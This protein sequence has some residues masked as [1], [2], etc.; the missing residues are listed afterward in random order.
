M[1]KRVRHIFALIILLSGA[2]QALAQMNMPDKVCVGTDRRYWVE[3]GLPGSIFTWTLDGVEIKSSTDSFV[4]VT[5]SKAKTYQ[6]QV[7]EH[8][9]TCDG[10]VQSGVVEVDDPVLPLFAKIDPICQ[11]SI[12]PL[13][14]LTSTNGIPGTWNPA[15]ISTATAGTSTY[16]FTPEAG[17]CATTTTLDI[18]ILKLTATPVA[19]NITCYGAGDGTFTVSG[20]SGGSGS[21]EYSIDGGISWIQESAL[22]L[23]IP[24]KGIYTVQMRD[25]VIPGCEISLG[26]VEI[27]EP[28]QLSA[29]PNYTNATCLGNDGTITVTGAKGGWGN[30]KY[31]I[32][33]TDWQSS[34]NF[35]GLLPGSYVVWI[36]DAEV[37]GCQISLGTIVIIKPEPLT[38]TLSKT[39]VTCFNGNDGTI[40]VSGPKNG[41]GKYEFSLDGNLWQSALQFTGLSAGPFT[42]QIRDSIAPGCVDTIG[43]VTLSEPDKLQASTSFT[44]VKCFG[45]HDGSISVYDAKGGSG[46]YQ[47]TVDGINWQSSQTFSGLAPIKYFVLMSDAKGQNCIEFISEITITEPLQMQASVVKNDISCNGAKDGK[48]LISNPAN[49]STPYQFTIDDGT[50]TPI[51]STNGSF[52]GLLK[53]DYNVKMS[54]AKGCEQALG[55]FTIVEPDPLTA[56]VASTNATCLGNDGTITITN[57]A[58]SVSGNYEYCINGTNWFA[59]GAFKNLASGTY[60]VKIRDANLSSCERIL[61][62]RIISEPTP[63]LATAQKTDVTCHG[64]NDG[65]I[66][67][68]THQ[69]GSGL[70]EYSVDGTNWNNLQ[71][72]SGLKPGSYTL[73]MHDT[74][75]P[76]CFITIGVFEIIEPDMLAATA[77]AFPVTCFGG[78]D[79]KITF[80][81]MSGGS[82][83]WEFSVDGT[84]W[85]TDKIEKLIAGVYTVQ[86]RDANHPTCAIS[87]NPIEITEPP[88]LTATVTPANVTCFGGIDGKISITHP[89]NGVGPYQFSLD[90]IKWQSD[91][92]FTGLSAGSYDVLI[93][94]DAN[95]CIANLA[96]VQIGQPDK[97]QATAQRTNETVPG[98]NDGSITI[99]GQNGGSGIYKYSLD[100]I[101]WQPE[102]VF[103]NLAP[104]SYTVSVGDANVDGCLITIPV[105]IS[106]AGTITA[107]YDLS[108]VTCFGGKDGSITFKN[109]TGAAKYQYSISGG[110]VWVDS[111][112][113]LGLSAGEY[114]LEVRDA[115]NTANIVVLG[116]VVINQ[117][118]VLDANVVVAPETFSGA[119]DG[120][121]T[122]NAK[123]GSGTY[124]YSINGTSW[125]ATN[126]FSGLTSATYTVSIR[127]KKATSC[128]ITFQKVI[129]PAGSLSADV[130][131]TNVMCKGDNSGIISISNQAGAASGK[132]NFS[133]DNGNTWK[134]APTIAGLTAG[135]YDVMIQDASNPLN[136][137]SLGKV[138]ILEPTI[139]LTAGYSGFEPPLCA[140]GTGK[141]IVTASGGTPPYTNTGTY[142]IPAGKTQTI[143][144]FDH[145]LC[146]ASLTFTMPNPNPI[147]AKA[148]API[149]GK[150]FADGGT[151]T[152]TA[153]GGSGVYFLNGK[154]LDPA[155]KITVN[156]PTGSL[157]SFI[158]KDAN[159]CQADPISGTMPGPD[160]LKINISPIEPLCSG[161]SNTVTVTATGGTGTH[162]YTGEGKFL[163]L[164]GV[165]TLTVTDANGC[166]ASGTIDISLKDPPPAPTVVVSELPNCITATGTIKVT[167]PLGNNYQYRIDGNTYQSGIDFAALA[168]GSTHTIQ[169]KDI[170]SGCESAATTKIV[171]KISAA[172]SAPLVVVKIKPDCNTP[173]GTIEI[174]SPIGTNFQYSIDGN[175]YQSGIDFAALAPL[176]NHSIKVK[177]NTTGCESSATSIKIDPVVGPPLTPTVRVAVLPNCIIATGTIEVTAPSGTNYQYSID[178]NTYQS[179][180]D[181]AG[182]APLSIHT[183]KVKDNTTGCESATSIKMDPVVSPPLAPTAISTTPDC[184][185]GVGTIKVTKPAGGTG[186]EYSFDGAAYT[187]SDSLNNQLAGSSHTI[188]VKDVL[189][190]CESAVTTVKINPLPPLPAT[191]VA[192]VTVNPTCN[193]P[194]GTVQVTSPAEGTGFEYSMDGG[195]YLST[196]TFSGLKT[197]RYT[198]KVRN[199]KT[200]CESDTTGVAVPALPPAPL[201]AVSGVENC[202]CYDGKGSISFTATNTPDGIY[203]ISYDGG[204]FANVQVTGGKAKVIVSAN[205][206]KNLTIEANGCVSDP[207]PEVT[208][209]QPNPIVINATIHEI[210]LKSKTKGS[211]VL[212][213]R[214]GSEA[215]LYNWHPDATLGYAGATTKDISNLENGEYTVTVTDAN[216]CTK[217][218]I[219][220]I[221]IPNYPP[222]AKDDD[223]SA[224]CGILS[225]NLLADNGHGKDYDPENDPIFLDT[226]LISKPAHGT[227]TL[228]HDQ[229]GAF[230]YKADQTYS[231]VDTFRY[232][233]TDIKQNVSNAAKVTIQIVA[234]FDGDGIPD[235][236]D[237]DADGD[238]ILNVDEVL[239]GQDWKTTDSDGDGHPNWLDIDSDND[240]IPDNI[241]A[242]NGKGPN[243]VEEPGKPEYVPPTGI[244]NEFGVDYAY[245]PAHG[246]KR[247]IPV[248]TDGDGIPDFLDTDSDND[249]V[250]DY[251]EGNDANHDGHPD[252]VALS[253][254]DDDGDGLDNVFD[255]VDRCSSPKTNM[256]GS[257]APL[258]DT[259]GNGIRDWRDPNDDGDKWPTIMED[260]NGD[261]IWWDDDSNH[262]GIPDYLDPARN[263]DML[264]PEAFSPNGDN[265]HDYFQV[266]CIDNYPN[267]RMYI[268]DQLGNKLYEKDHYGNVGY[269]GSY[270]RAWWDGRT[271]NRSIVTNNGM[272]LPGTYF[273]VLELG[274]GQVRKSYVF[275]SY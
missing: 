68:L 189:T 194:N 98:A 173:T 253:G 94:H 112:Y 73:Q 75:S 130:S 128:T 85:V 225:G 52:T 268:F 121:L 138:D 109:P 187:S 77:Q 29:I 257:N 40:T 195:S 167:F 26:T 181:F 186:F 91:S 269:W 275:V 157:Y 174:S 27:K 185:T 129:N 147:I 87:M 249:G 272:V 105:I 97:L 61:D 149:P 262:N 177:D 3:K 208:V 170:T 19:T 244:V 207:V 260:W 51:T 71:T 190:G 66:T 229:S 132:Y 59:N 18:E 273:Y 134:S 103:Y 263:C 64:A 124:E 2:F 25:K 17:Q 267:A 142:T 43:A 4:V 148:D 143:K 248:D 117:P 265:I 56:D 54:D 271:T 127:D 179:G 162:P 116:N 159:N 57:P 228:N 70:Y 44:N 22:P 206:Y 176:S 232:V 32:N 250:P 118:N 204:Q 219:I 47:F 256:I 155:G 81:N 252:F 114:T 55:S 100:G 231:G 241:E 119:G 139:K 192:N 65:T 169:V 255:I 84:N 34:G 193:N 230:E 69:G 270:D 92:T 200:G 79:G 86:I 62:T 63:L 243:S 172:P 216:G 39:D 210:D 163:L 72:I 153:T 1:V 49:G 14:P 224:G 115:G 274:N 38:A 90:G 101:N 201:L 141:L 220:T 237:Q 212:Y 156:V 93:I 158:I 35:T 23:K 83:A 7:Q 107:E 199:V 196:A 24:V 152:L 108:N 223:F 99:T 6:L 166:S 222:V 214:G 15:T 183:I 48:I 80:S 211:I 251:I 165:H 150:C 135:T 259:D 136:K 78:N 45:A 178:G 240:G 154:K 180:I 82:G 264:I 123:G 96:G 12:A 104:A 110:T 140:D 120:S 33:G 16:T 227:I 233:I 50:G 182:L 184:F 160:E 74:N 11:N 144:I 234:D 235:D 266:F 168:P 261:G 13:L 245:D 5:W 53:G 246:G 88:K 41:S 60:E 171:D 21:F 213:V 239:P 258:Q 247:L 8:Q 137:V 191:P 89:K 254:K 30:Y 133:V 236:I 238:G 146:S 126:V 202:L 102:S 36:G 20:A 67:I 175:T 205:T 197:K 122:V 226:T 242:Q 198:F 9:L 203:A 209:T 28:D 37:T 42:V 164:S 188:K 131:H 76:G 113:S 95:S 10:I 151:V 215:Y 58:N 125:Q 221:P 145:N 46:T 217:D 31:S 218:T 111:P 106:P 161:N